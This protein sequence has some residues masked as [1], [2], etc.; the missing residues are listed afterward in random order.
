FYQFQIHQ[1]KI[2]H[3]DA[4]PG[5]FLFQ[6]D[7]TVAVLDF[8]CVKEISEEFYQTY[9]QL[10]N[11]KVLEDDA[12]LLAGAKAAQI[13]LDSDTPEQKALFLEIFKEALAMICQPFHAETFDFGDEAFFGRIYEYGER[14][15]KNKQLRTSITPRGDKDGIYV[16]R[17][18]FGL[19]S[20]LNQ[21][22]AEIETRRHMPQF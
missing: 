16:N 22:G 7:G 4:H 6:E 14:M 9:F 18:Y 5:N 17:T 2:T 21:L 13:L 11:P 10:L 20:I 8:G 3:A 15:G 12:S 1:L 19:F